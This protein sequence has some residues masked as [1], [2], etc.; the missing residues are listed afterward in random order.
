MQVCL[1]LGRLEACLCFGNLQF[2]LAVQF[3]V[4]FV[5]YLF[6]PH[7]PFASF[8]SACFIVHKNEALGGKVW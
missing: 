5:N 6:F 7:S 2:L 1:A 3:A 4:L 8:V